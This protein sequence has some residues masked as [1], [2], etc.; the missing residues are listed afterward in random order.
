[1]LTLNIFRSASRYRHLCFIIMYVCTHSPHTYSSTSSYSLPH[2]MA[3]CRVSLEDCRACE[4]TVLVEVQV[5]SAAQNQRI[6]SASSGTESETVQYSRFNETGQSDTLCAGLD[7]TILIIELFRSGAKG[8]SRRII[9]ML[10]C[11]RLG[12]GTI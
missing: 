3:R 4:A 2:V 8:Y 1:M 9:N 5:G 11:D 6:K 12:I 10:H 7:W